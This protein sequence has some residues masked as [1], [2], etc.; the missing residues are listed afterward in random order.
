MEYYEYA[1]KIIKICTL[2]NKC[3]PMMKDKTSRITIDT[4]IEV[5]TFDD[6]MD[7]LFYNHHPLIDYKI[8]WG[9]E[10]FGYNYV[11]SQY[12]RYTQAKFVMV[13]DPNVHLCYMSQNDIGI[14][15]YEIQMQF[16]SP[17]EHLFQ[18]GLILGDRFDGYCI[19]HALHMLGFDEKVYIHL[20]S[21]DILDEI[22]EK[23]EVHSVKYEAKF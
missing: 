18:M 13:F 7:I 11:S 9:G 5:Y 17:E 23:M 16:E 8:A 1:R 21:M 14:V 3:M 4:T 22:I 2:M 10:A 12:H 6:K 20:H 19:L 15:E